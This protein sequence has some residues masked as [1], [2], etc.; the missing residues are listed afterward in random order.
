[1]GLP[2]K[3]LER[4]GTSTICGCV[5]KSEGDPLRHA[6]DRVQRPPTKPNLTFYQTPFIHHA[7]SGIEERL[8]LCF[9]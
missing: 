1:M 4:A 7:M 3:S 8:S 5:A 9:S 2:E 6:R